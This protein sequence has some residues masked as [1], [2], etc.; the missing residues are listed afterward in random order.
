MEKEKKFSLGEPL[1]ARRIFLT[2]V[3]GQIIGTTV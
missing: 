1:K 3:N 2:F